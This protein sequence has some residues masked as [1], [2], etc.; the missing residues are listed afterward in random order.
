MH[1]AVEQQTL[2]R[3]P[4][5]VKI[6]EIHSLE[7]LRGIPKEINSEVHLSFI[8]KEWNKFYKQ[9]A[10][11]TKQGDNMVGAKFNP[12]VRGSWNQYVLLCGSGSCGW[13]R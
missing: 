8:R 7:N 6:E 5:L 1:H 4:D 11:L 12:P 13:A 2:K 3:Y 10:S 9:T